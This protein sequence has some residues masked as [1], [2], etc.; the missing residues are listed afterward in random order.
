MELRQNL[1]DNE[2]VHTE[3]NGITVHANVLA[4]DQDITSENSS[5]KIQGNGYHNGNKVFFYVVPSM[6]IFF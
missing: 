2:N 4:T 1:I 3:I 6:G 5:S